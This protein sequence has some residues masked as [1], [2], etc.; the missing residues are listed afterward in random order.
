MKM[1]EIAKKLLSSKD[2]KFYVKDYTDKMLRGVIISGISQAK[3]ILSFEDDQ[4]LNAYIQLPY[5]SL[6]QAQE[7]FLQRSKSDLNIEKID[8]CWVLRSF[9]DC[10][11]PAKWLGQAFLQLKKL[12]ECLMLLRHPVAAQ[13]YLSL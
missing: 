3:F 10:Q 12:Q 2:V 8:G 9:G 7:L 13:N 11:N 1:Q 4:N 5:S 6:N